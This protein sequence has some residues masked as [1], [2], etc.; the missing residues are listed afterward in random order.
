MKDAFPINEVKATRF[1]PSVAEQNA[2]HSIS[3]G[4][5]C[6]TVEREAQSIVLNSR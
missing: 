2:T 3:L 6:S 5:S 1:E 4:V